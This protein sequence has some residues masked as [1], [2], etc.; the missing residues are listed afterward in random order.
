MEEGKTLKIPTE[1]KEEY[2][3]QIFASIAKRY[4]LLNSLLSFGFHHSWKRFAIEKA[5]VK[6][7]DKALDVCSGTGDLAILLARKVGPSGSVVALDL[8][9]EMLLV[10]ERKALASNTAG[11]IRFAQGNAEALDFPSGSFDAVTVAFGIRNVGSIGRAFHEMHRVLSQGG[12]AV[13]L[14]FSHP[15][16]S[17]L[18]AL[19]DLYSFRV[20]PRVGRFVS[21]DPNAYL[22]LP[23]SIREF[24]DQASLKNTM[25]EAGFESVHCYNLAGGIVALHMGTK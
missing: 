16:N 12:R 11:I 10:A 14:E 23:S 8:S 19:Y 13:C 4:D 5:G 1:D 21:K 15:P 3:H 22:Y 2:V 7:G 20:I 17:L 9:R 18:R 24:P 6:S 25:K